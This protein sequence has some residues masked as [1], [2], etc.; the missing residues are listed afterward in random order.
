MS[1]NASIQQLGSGLA[2]LTAGLVI[3]RAPDGTLTH[4]GIVGWIAVACTLLAIWLAQRIRIVD[5]APR[6]AS[7]SARERREWLTWPLP[8]RTG[9][10][11]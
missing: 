3:G 2:A 6:T 7:A 1:F 11:R 4:Y 8:A 5:D 10:I 9:N